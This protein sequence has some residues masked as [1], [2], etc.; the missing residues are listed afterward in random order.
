MP[1]ADY[2]PDYESLREFLLGRG[3]PAALRFFEWFMDREAA[4]SAAGEFFPPP[5]RTRAA[6]GDHYELQCRLELT[7]LLR[8]DAVPWFASPRLL[9]VIPKADASRPAVDTGTDEVAWDEVCKGPFDVGSDLDGIDFSGGVNLAAQRFLDRAGGWLPEN[10]KLVVGVAGVVELASV[11]FGNEAF[12]IGLVE[13]PAWMGEFLDRLG[14]SLARAADEVTQRPETG[15]LV[16]GDDMGMRT[17]LLVRPE[18]LRR[19]VVPHHA[20][21]VELARARGIPAVLHSCGNV[22]EI[23]PELIHTAGFDAKQSFDDNAWPVEAFKARWGDAIVTLG[24]VDM[25]LLA[26]DDQPALRR[27]VRQIM[28]ACWTDGRFAMGSGH[29]LAAYTPVR[30]FL[31][32]QAEALA[33]ADQGPAQ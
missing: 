16:I 30:N 8:L 20:R 23:M 24:G 19:W 32:M 28:A 27:R 31:I 12:F 26:R 5:D 29:C 17:G 18:V 4:L 21:C 25:T 6:D 14:Q 33:F 22:A 3:D 13:Q 11:I 15:V 1:Q 7:K 2:V 9:H 10:L